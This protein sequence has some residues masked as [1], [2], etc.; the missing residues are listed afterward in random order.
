MNSNNLILGGVLIIAAILVSPIIP[1][2][3]IFL[4]LIGGILVL[5]QLGKLLPGAIELIRRGIEALRNHN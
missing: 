4:G 2:V 1:P 3:S 5:G